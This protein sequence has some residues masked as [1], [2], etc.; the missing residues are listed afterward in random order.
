MMYSFT[1]GGG[2]SVKVCEDLQ[3][4]VELS[5]ESVSVPY[6]ALQSVVFDIHTRSRNLILI[7]VVRTTRSIIVRK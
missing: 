2:T 7:V 5:D 6:L 1:C 4:V 3:P